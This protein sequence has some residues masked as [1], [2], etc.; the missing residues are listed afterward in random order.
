MLDWATKAVAWARGLFAGVPTGPTPTPGVQA[1]AGARLSVLVTE[2]L[3]SEVLCHG[4][5]PAPLPPAP[6][7]GEQPVKVPARNAFGEPL[8]E[9]P[10]ADDR[11]VV[12][13]AS[14]LTST[15]VRAAAFV[16]LEGVGDAR[17]LLSA[18]A[19]RQLALV[20]HAGRHGR[21]AAHDGVMAAADT[22]AAVAMG[23]DAQE[24]VDLA[25][26]G[27]ALAEDALLPVVLGWDGDDV[28][29]PVHLPDAALVRQLV[30]SPADLVDNAQAAQAE[31]FGPQRRRLPRWFDLGHP[32]A[33]G[34]LVSGAQ[35]DATAAGR[36][37]FFSRH[38]GA[39]LDGI[40]AAVS[41][42][43]GRRVA[44]L[45]SHQMAGAR[46]AVVAQGSVV[47]TAEAAADTVRD[48]DGTAAGVLGITWL[49]P[50]AADKLREALAGVQAI[51]VLERSGAP[52]GADG[53]LT[54]EVRAV[55]G[56]AVPRLLTV[57]Y[58]L[59]GQAPSETEL[60][61][62]FRDMAR[63]DG[64]D[65]LHLGIDVPVADESSPKRQLALQ[66]ANRL[67]PELENMAVPGPGASAARRDLLPSPGGL[68]LAVRRLGAEATTW[69]NVPR[70]W[71]ATYLPLSGGAATQ[72]EPW[73]SLDVLP[74]G[75]ATFR[76]RRGMQHHVP[77][78][79]TAAC[80]GCGD[81]WI[82]CPDAAIAPVAAG[83][84]DLL[85][86]AADRAAAAGTPQT[87]E[88]G[89][90]KRAHK[91]LAG[92]VEGQLAKAGAGLLSEP[93]LQESWSWLAE[94]M[95]IGADERA[96]FDEAFAATLGE[97]GRLPLVATEALFVAPHKKA[98]GS[99]LLLGLAVNAQSCQGCGLC[100]AACAEGAIALQPPTP[101]LLAAQAAGHKA[102]EGSP[103][104]SGAVVAA[105]LAAQG[106][107][108]L[109]AVE[110]SRAC[111]MTLAGGDDAE[112]GS[113]ARLATRMVTAAVEYERQRKAQVQAERLSGLSAKLRTA[114]DGKLATAV[115][116]AD[117]DSLSA[118]LDAAPGKTS[119]A[120]GV[121]ARLDEL[122][123]RASLD[124]PATRRLVSLAQRIGHGLWQLA[125][126]DAGV[127]A[128]RYGVVLAGEKVASWA[129][130]WP[131]NPFTVPVTV[132]L[133]DAGPDVAAGVARGLVAQRTAE[134]RAERLAEMALSGASDLPEQEVR[135]GSLGW[136]GLEQAE[137][138]A[139][140]PV[141]LVGDAACLTGP[142]L[143]GV[144]R[145]LQSDL[146]VK[147]LLLDDRELPVQGPDPVMLALAHGGVYAASTSIDAADHLF[148]AVA[149]A[150]SWA[151]PALLHVH[152]PSPSA[153]GFETDATVQRARLAVA[154]RVH[155]LV[156][157][158]PAVEGVLGQRIALDGN[159]ALTSR[160][161]VDAE[162]A[163]LTPAVWAAGEKRFEGQRMT[164]AVAE[165][166]AHFAAL[167]ELAGLVTPFTA[168]V[169]SELEREL[170]G[171]H[172]AALAALKAEYEGKI[173]ALAQSQAAEH[174]ARLKARLM[175]LAGQGAGGGGRA[176]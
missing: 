2:S 20:V 173:A 53:P 95:N 50:L 116:G 48:N 163:E 159:P 29:H 72:P 74:A 68:P 168:E 42:K 162:G 57:R 39:Q 18:A 69:D 90:L 38:T 59:G 123:E 145:L 32:A 40:L 6:A 114:I 133:G 15:G 118:A 25:L 88:A 125:E 87:A 23:A 89:K 166:Q 120:T 1:V 66:V 28:A 36:E 158:N 16:T 107:S 131:H 143:A 144:R 108:K 127:G 139:C 167:Q 62:L 54:R 85:D 161:S 30:G 148:T 5:L 8:T 149:E 96:A 113:G 124:G 109:A 152:A 135:L 80:N 22:G 117:L 11:G 136:S 47:A 33:Q 170:R 104:A 156:R 172:D 98:K 141:L 157:Y 64:A 122:G 73:L 100:A 155:P 3:G 35:V 150:M 134:A 4:R 9:T 24:A 160:W 34:A 165:R 129:A 106:I 51:A 31:V 10:A 140:P 46:F 60:V 102:W 75:T 169:R 99:G 27:R 56:A 45:R 115:S 121:L 101:D 112:A 43:T 82:G 130:T 175:Q 92:R 128:A 58:G 83:V 154:S 138:D 26:V 164:A 126:G 105:A 111:L 132:A 63:G 97:L 110:L 67:A 119:K 65:A 21:A 12:A 93:L 70:F 19:R 44:R 171:E 14:G 103:D 7:E 142:G 137:R 61:Q 76:D 71:G 174:A 176:N 86:A 55:L 91:Q 37:L 79:D 13:A 77:A 41:R 94:K 151:G 146:P 17:D 52:L 81:C 147:L 153:H 78:I 84:Q 49:R